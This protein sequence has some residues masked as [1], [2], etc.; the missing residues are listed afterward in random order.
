MPVGHFEKTDLIL[1]EVVAEILTSGVQEQTILGAVL[2]D[3]TS[4]VDMNHKDKVVVPFIGKFDPLTTPANDNCVPTVCQKLDFTQ[5]EILSK[6]QVNFCW[7]MKEA[8]FRKDFAKD[9]IIKQAILAGHR[10]ANLDLYTEIGANIVVGNTFDGT[11]ATGDLLNAIYSAENWLYDSGVEHNASNSFLIG[12]GAFKSRL[13]QLK[14]LTSCCGEFVNPIKD[15]VAG[16]AGFSFIQVP[17]G[18]LPANTA[19]AINKSSGGFAMFMSKMAQLPQ[20]DL[21]CYKYQMIQDYGIKI[22]GSE[23]VAKISL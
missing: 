14:V 19:Y 20:T 1:P 10:K 3:Y 16:V 17:T 2:S 21:L 12:D 6:L 4:L 13:Q 5:V 7:E 11:I 18:V 22:F 8:F 15:I 23:Y 9:Q